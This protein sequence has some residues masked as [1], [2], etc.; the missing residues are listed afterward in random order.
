MK[1]L[2]K[3]GRKKDSKKYYGHLAVN[4]PEPTGDNFQGLSKQWIYGFIYLLILILLKLSLSTKRLSR[5]L[6]EIVIQAN[7]Q[8]K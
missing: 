4:A 3:S 2:P 8:T 6:K 5:I 7:N 1:H